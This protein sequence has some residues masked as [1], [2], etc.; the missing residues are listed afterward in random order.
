M[1][2]LSASPT[3]AAFTVV[4]DGTAQV[5]SGP[6]AGPWTAVGP[7]S[8]TFALQVD[9]DRLFT[10]EFRETIDDTTV[11]V[12]DPDPHVV[13]L[14]GGR[15][16]ARGRLR[17]RPG[18]P[19]DGRRTRRA[20]LAHGGGAHRRE[21][22]PTSVASIDLRDDGR[23][24]VAT[25]EGELFD[26]P[27]GGSPLA[28]SPA[29]PGSARFAGE[30]IVFRRGGGALRVI[31]PGGRVRAFGVRSTRLGEF[32][33]DGTRVLWEANGC[34]LVAP[35]TDPA[36]AAPEPGP[37]PRSELTRVDGPNPRLR[38]TIPVTLRC[39]AAPRTCRGTLRLKAD[40]ALLNRAAAVRDPRG[41][42]APLHGAARRARVSRA[43]PPRRSATTGRW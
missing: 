6:P 4:N 23:A 36:A 20:R 42:R 17:R 15:A 26:V 13:P 28:G 11:T 3:R 27:P 43:A 30:H 24:L 8:L 16:G 2:R 38:R 12:R 37:C 34:L 33:T 39:V 5:F 9:G 32:T 10:F 31:D 21:A 41:T 1:P 19:R 18:G 14:P 25:D 22:A 40:G 7:H 29:Q 35:V